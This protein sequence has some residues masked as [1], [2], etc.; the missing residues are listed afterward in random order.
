MRILR[1]WLSEFVDLD[2]IHDDDTLAALFSRAGIEVAAR[3]P[4]ETGTIFE[5]EV[6]ANRPDL[7]CHRGVARELAALMETPMKPSTAGAE[8]D[9]GGTYPI[10]ILA[11]Q[12]SRYSGVVLRNI[13]V[14]EAPSWMADRI[15]AMDLKPISNVVDATNYALFE[16]NHPLHA[17]D[18]DKLDGEIQVRHARDGERIALLDGTDR[19]LT[20]DDLVIADSRRAVALAGV[21]GGADTAVTTET[22]NLL[23]EAAWFDPAAVRKTARRLGISTDSSYRFERGADPEGTIPALK[24]LVSLIQNTAGGEIEHGVHDVRREPVQARFAA[25][26]PGRIRDMLGHDVERWE[27]KLNAI[28]VTVAGGQ[29]ILP[30]WRP[31]LSREIDLIEE[32]AR[33][34]GYD[35]IRATLPFRAGRTRDFHYEHAD[36]SRYRSL[37][38]SI[39]DFATAQGFD[40]CLNFS[41]DRPEG[42]DVEL[43]NP[44][45]AEES[46]LRGSLL[47][48]LLRTAGLR[49]DR[50]GENSAFLFEMD[51]IFRNGDAAPEERDC[52]AF[53]L[54]GRAEDRRYD[55]RAADEI[56]I[57]HLLG[58]LR[59]LS[60]TLRVR[61]EYRPGNS[62]GLFQARFA[63]ALFQTFAAILANDAPCGIA[64]EIRSNGGAKVYGAELDLY[65]LHGIVAEF[66]P[67]RYEP[68]PRYPGSTRDLAFW[69]ASDT[70]VG[71]LVDAARAAGVDILESCEIFDVFTAKAAAGAVPRKSVALRLSFRS[72]DRTL[73]EEEVAE[74]TRRIKER[75]CAACGGELRAS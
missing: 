52:A 17:F 42:G 35:K 28:G 68:L 6:T 1:S 41:F 4:S 75:I 55:G 44:I 74:G 46:V 2:S 61:I 37:K 12:C 10:Q 73:T 26:R 62:D 67:P 24:L 43:L 25:M 49:A 63:G 23:L 22:K 7:L 33:L 11:P 14:T 19:L 5:V 13:T 27:G 59:A 53:L 66:A 36:A 71:S 34:D 9:S 45:N 18:L 31:D 8:L 72:K 57:D 65:A 47:P 48:S 21:M 64:G 54:S 50:A 20:R 56:T 32:L 38:E 40:R 69:I 3:M 39:A 30:S 60:N 58:I 29:A 70:L 15:S 51:K 16:L